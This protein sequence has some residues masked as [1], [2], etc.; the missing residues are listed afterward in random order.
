MKMYVQKVIGGQSRYFY[1]SWYLNNHGAPCVF[2][3]PFRDHH[4][5]EDL[6]S[7]YKFIYQLKDNIQKCINT[8][9]DLSIE[10]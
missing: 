2:R 5:N 10:I 3:T 7:L 8:E 1:E 6:K 4:N 9:T